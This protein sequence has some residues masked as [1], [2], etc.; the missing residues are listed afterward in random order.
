MTPRGRSE[1]ILRDAGFMVGTVER[2]IPANTGRPFTLRKDLFGLFDTLAVM[3]PRVIGIQST[4]RPQMSAHLRSYVTDPALR[5]SAYRWLNSQGRD[6]EIWGWEKIKNRWTPTVW[7]VYLTSAGD[8]EVIKPPKDTGC[9]STPISHTAKKR[10]P[11]R[12]VAPTS[13]AA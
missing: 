7:K 11:R 8:I 3:G 4:T 2:L 13:T 5:L 10:K 12:S 1:G 9:N 6:F